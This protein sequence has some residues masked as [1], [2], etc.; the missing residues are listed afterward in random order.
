MNEGEMTLG[1]EH[2]GFYL[3]EYK[4]LARLYCL[5]GGYHLRIRPDGTVDGEREEADV[6]TVLKT[7]AVSVGVV[8]IE[9]VEAGRYLA[10]DKEGQLYGSKTVNEECRFQEKIEENNY[11]TYR[12]QGS[13]EGRWYLG[14]KKSGRPKRGTRTRLGQKGV[15]FLPRQAGGAGGEG[16][17]TERTPNEEGLAV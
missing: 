8:V 13:G 11:N 17:G 7:T 16:G 14:L 6:Y 2:I 9:G 3:P 5:N 12:S 1:P 4:T 10:M 15:Y